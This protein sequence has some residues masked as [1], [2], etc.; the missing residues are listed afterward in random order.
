MTEWHGRR[1]EEENDKDHNN[2]KQNKYKNTNSDKSTA[3]E[4]LKEPQIM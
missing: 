4:G 2:D 3:K 1:S